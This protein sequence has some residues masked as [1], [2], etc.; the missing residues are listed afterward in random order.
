MPGRC[1]LMISAFPPP[2]SGQSLAAKLLRDG[3]EASDYRVI[4]IDIGDV[5]GASSVLKRICQLAG[6]EFHLLKSCIRERDCIVYLQLGHGRLSIFRDMFFMATS[7]ITRH[8]CIAHVH[9]SGFR[10]A[11]NGLSLPLRMIEKFLIG[12]LKAAV[13][14]SDSLKQ[15]FDGLLAPERIFAVDN[16]ID[17]EFV[18]L[19]DECVDRERH[20]DSF[21]ILFLSN[22][23]TAKGFS[24]LL[25]TAVIARDQGRNWKFR[26]AGARVP[27]QD[28]DI[29]AFIRDYDLTNVVADDVIEGRAKHEAYRDADVFVLPSE[30]EGQPLCILEAMFESLPVVTTRVGG[31]PEIFST[32][33]TCAVYTEPNDPM[34]LYTALDELCSS[35]EMWHTISRRIRAIAMNRFT[36]QKHIDRMVEIIYSPER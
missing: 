20:S 33:E 24:T 26:F 36:A 34:A 25:R 15:M 32:D 30:Y 22:Y 28:V 10:T 9:G 3:L 23:L 8:P 21:N 5:L 18:A 35:P 19:T 1:L 17:P 11:Y 27:N 13:V 14:L 31:I 4:P 7:W 29:D 16:G 12:K 6:I 2:V